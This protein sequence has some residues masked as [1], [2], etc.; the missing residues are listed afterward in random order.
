MEVKLKALLL[1]R[2]KRAV[3]QSVQK[4]DRGR[5]ADDRILD[6]LYRYAVPLER[7]VADTL[8]AGII[9]RDVRY[10]RSVACSRVRPLNVIQLESDCAVQDT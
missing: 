3:G 1:V 2:R 4:G 10:N 8:R 7:Y 9:G 5:V 6:Y